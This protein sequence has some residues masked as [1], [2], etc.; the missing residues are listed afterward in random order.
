MNPLSGLAAAAAVLVLAGC[1]QEQTEQAAHP[2]QVTQGVPEQPSRPGAPTPEG[3]DQDAGRASATPGVAT[4]DAP[5]AT[6]AK[7]DDPT[8]GQS[9]TERPTP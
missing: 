4:S 7:T 2:G 6:G 3:Q 1:T 8:P 5:L 9:N